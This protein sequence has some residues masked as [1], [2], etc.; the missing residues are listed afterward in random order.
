LEFPSLNGFNIVAQTKI[1][2]NRI[3]TNS[4]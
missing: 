2:Y 4:I 1:G 3:P